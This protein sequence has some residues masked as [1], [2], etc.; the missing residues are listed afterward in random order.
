MLG[1]IHD[2]AVFVVVFFLEFVSL[3]VHLWLVPELQAKV[4][5]ESHAVLR[6]SAAEADADIGAEATYVNIAFHVAVGI[7]L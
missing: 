4:K 7:G 6:N 2:I 5:L 3:T 1:Y